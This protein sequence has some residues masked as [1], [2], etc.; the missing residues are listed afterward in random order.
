MGG[1]IGVGGN[2]T[3]AAE[4]NIY[5]EEAIANEPMMSSIAHSLCIVKLKDA[6]KVEEVK[7]KIF[8]NCDPRKWLCVSPEYILV[9]DSGDYIAFAMPISLCLPQV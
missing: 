9:V 1:S 4:F 5:V 8:D 2:T 7:Q 6:S 3:I